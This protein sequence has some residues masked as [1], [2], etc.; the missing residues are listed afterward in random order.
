MSRRTRL[1]ILV[2]AVLGLAAGFGWYGWRR[3][4]APS[5][6]EIASAGLDPELAGAIESARQQVR[7]DPYS[8]AAWG[9]LGK[10]LRA[11][12]LL[13]EAVVCFA[14]AERLAPTDPQWPYLQGEAL[15]KSDARAALPLLE[16][17][18]DLAGRAFGVAPHLRLAEVLLALGRGDEAEGQLRQALDIE[19]DDP[20]THYNLGV[21]AFARGDLPESLAQLK[22]CEDSPFTRQKACIQL[23][24]VCRRMNRAEEGDEYG[25]KAD[26]LPPDENW[27]DPLAA[28]ALTVGRSA[29]FQQAAEL[30]TRGFHQAAAEQLT[31]LIEQRPAYQV[32]L[33]LA[34]NLR[35]MGD[36]AG[37]EQAL[38]S[39]VSMEPGNFK[40]YYELSRIWCV[41]A[42]TDARSDKARAKKEY[43]EAADW[44]R[45]ALARRGDHALTHV[46]LGMSLRELGMSKEAVDSYRTAIEC[47][48]DLAEA[49]LLLG[50]TLLDAGQLA[51]ARTSLERAARL[52]PTHDARLRAALARLRKSE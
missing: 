36:L 11:S 25:R 13:D 24:A 32:Y 2:V 40:A 42:Q 26:Q 15:R 1:G 44:A 47:S 16:R 49:H 3:Y 43:Q 18:A 51:E 34:R 7:K 39:A 20:S 19:P 52:S 46:I 12:Q 31:K 9:K 4:T 37:A 48:P 50:E 35:K 5:P 45:R 33:A 8:A 30:E 21:L 41:R 38:L 23:A 17:A 6:P 29:R 14:Q 22:R 10:M 28:E 27:P